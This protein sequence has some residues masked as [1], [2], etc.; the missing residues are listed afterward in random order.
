MIEVLPIPMNVDLD[1]AV[2]LC[3]E[4]LDMDGIPT[5]CMREGHDTPFA[6][7]GREFS[8]VFTVIVA[9]SDQYFD[10]IIERFSHSP[11]DMNEGLFFE[12]LHTSDS[13]EY[14]R[15]HHIVARITFDHLEIVSEGCEILPFFSE[16][17]LTKYIEHLSIAIFIRDDDIFLISMQKTLQ[18]EESGSRTRG[19]RIRQHSKNKQLTIY[20]EHLHFH[21]I[22]FFCFE[23]ALS[24]MDSGIDVFLQIM[25]ISL[26]L[27]FG[28]A[29]IGF[30]GI[31]LFLE[32]LAHGSDSYLSFFTQTMCNLHEITTTFFSQWRYLDHERFAIV[33]WIESQARITDSLL[34][35]A[36]DGLVPRLDDYCLSVKCGYCSN[37]PEGLTTPI[38]HH[39]DAFDDCWVRSSSLEFRELI[40]EVTLGFRELLLKIC[41]HSD[42]Y[43]YNTNV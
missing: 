14:L 38:C 39:I 23:N 19:V 37:V 24:I 18:K 40:L 28:Y 11:L 3:I 5:L 31:D 20:N 10:H 27:I 8:R 43:N 12:I 15:M 41:K 42:K 6:F 13:F 29:F 1:D 7:V 22:F 36:N 33:R 4:P 35:I 21:N 16:D 17:H 2:D 32:V 9:E 30:C 25:F 26:C 34:D